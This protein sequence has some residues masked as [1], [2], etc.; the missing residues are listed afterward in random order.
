VLIGRPE[1]I[2]DGLLVGAKDGT[3]LASSLGDS[4]GVVLAK[5][6]GVSECVTLGRSEGANDSFF[7]CVYHEKYANGSSEVFGFS[8]FNT[9]RQLA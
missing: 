6:L 5:T 4:D 2:H 3:I 8:Y 1:G 7:A 9:F